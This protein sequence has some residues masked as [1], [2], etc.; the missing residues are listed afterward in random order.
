M[1]FDGA[2]REMFDASFIPGIRALMCVVL[3]NPEERTLITFAGE[4]SGPTAEAVV[5]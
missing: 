4:P 3:G 5:Q 1:K 2:V